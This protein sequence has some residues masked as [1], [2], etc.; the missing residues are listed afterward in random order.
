MMTGYWISVAESSRTSTGLKLLV[1]K[2]GNNS[3]RRGMVEG[4]LRGPLIYLGPG[5]E[6]SHAGMC[7]SKNREQ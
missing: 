6:K 7:C 5:K 1:D 2:K 4:R 3:I